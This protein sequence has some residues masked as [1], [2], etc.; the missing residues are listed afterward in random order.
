LTGDTVLVTG[1]AG[2]IGSTVAIELK[3]SAP[4]RRVVALDSLRRRGSELNLPRLQ[5]AGVEFAHGDVRQVDDVT[6]H[7]RDA[8]LVIDCSAE[9]S[10]LAGYDGNPA[11]VVDSN[12]LGTINCLDLARRNQADVVFLSTSRVYPIAA[13]NA[14]AVVEEPTRFRIVP[15]QQ[16]AGLSA[17]GVA[18]AF[19]LDGSRSLYGA[20]KLA[21]ELLLQEYGAMYGLRFVINRL[22]VVSGPGQMGRVEQGVFALWMARHYFGGELE[23]RGWGGTGKQVRDVLHVQDVWDLVRRQIA[24]MDAVNGRTYNAGGGVANSISLREATVLCE[25]ITGRTIPVRPI[26]DTHPGD[27]RLY[28]TDNARVTRDIG[29]TPGHDLRAIFQD[30]H[31]WIR[32]EEAHVRRI[33][34]F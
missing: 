33:F 26:G 25:E 17:D 16:I 30:I 6:R 5:D 31:G 1:G 11:N 28:C 24:D 15:G 14:I 10:V 34:G 27:I 2:F 4:P 32:R 7:G 29:W 23:Y 20:T 22:G 18:E 8:G 21:S 3:R 9:P 12:L 13:L 19:P